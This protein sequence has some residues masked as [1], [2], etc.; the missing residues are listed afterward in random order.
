MLIN[1]ISFLINPDPLHSLDRSGSHTTEQLGH[2]HERCCRRWTFDPDDRPELGSHRG[3]D[4]AESL[5]RCRSRRGCHIA[6][7][8]TAHQHG[9]SAL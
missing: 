6:G 4:T 8:C 3:H 9:R 1:Y 5:K 2:G 7:K